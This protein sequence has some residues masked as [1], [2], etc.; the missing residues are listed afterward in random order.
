M[1]KSN[2]PTEARAEEVECDCSC[3]L[4][5]ECVCVCVH[6]HVCVREMLREYAVPMLLKNQ[7][8]LPI[9]HRLDHIS[10]TL[11]IWCFKGS[12]LISIFNEALCR[13]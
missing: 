12:F 1:Q 11:R 10:L 7:S 6:A 4:F 8:L 9:N 5:I 2:H 3:V 13:K